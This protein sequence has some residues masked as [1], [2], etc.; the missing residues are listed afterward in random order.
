[1]SKSRYTKLALACCPLFLISWNTA[2]QEEEKLLEEIVVTASSIRSSLQ[3]ALDQK[4]DASSLVEVIKAEDIGKLPDQNLAEV[5][6]NVTGIQIT[7]TAG[8]GTGVQIRGTDANRTEINGVS[9]V[10]SGAGRSGINF[11]DVSA[12]IIAAVEVT[13]SPEAKTIEGSVGGTINL[14]TIRPLDLDEPLV[15]A[16]VQGE[17]SSLSEDGGASPRYSG[18][19]GNSWT[20]EHGDFGVVI[21]AS[22]SEQNANAFRPRADRDNFVAAGGNPSSDDQFLPNQFFVQDYDDFEFETTNF[23]GAFEWQANDNLKLYFDAVLNDQQRNEASSRVQTSGLSSLRSVANI[24]EFENVDFGS[25]QGRN[26]SQDLG[27]IDAAVRGIIPAQLDGDLDPNLRFSGDTNSR[28]TESEILRIGG[29]W[30]EEKWTLR[31][32]ASSSTSDTETPSINTT[33]N[34]INPNTP[35]GTANE[36]G[37]PIE[38]DLTGGALTFGIAESEA[39]A[40]T[41]EQLLNP[42]NYR[43]RDINVSQDIAENTEDAFRVDFTYYT[44]WN[45]ITSIDV[46]YRY[47]ETTSLRDEVGSN[48]SLRQLVDSPSGDSFAD[49][50]AAGPDN[51]NDADGRDL[52]FPDFLTIDPGQVE[53]NPQAVLDGLNEAILAH[54]AITGSDEGGI[55]SPSS[56]NAAFFDISEETQA[57]YAQANFEYGPVR[58]NVG[59]RYIDTDLTSR[60]NTELIEEDGTRTITPSVS[61]SSYDLFL[62]RFNLVADVTENVLVRFGYS[63]D[64]RRPDFDDLS[65]AFTFSTSPNPAVDTG[66]PNLVPEEVES[67]DLSADWYFAPASV[68]SVGLFYK[69][70]NG[71][72]TNQDSAPFEDPVTG[73]RD[74]TDPCEGGGIFNPIADPNVFAPPG[75]P[76]GVCVPVTQTINGAGTT[77][78]EGIEIT[79]QYDLGQF[80]EQL[81]WA[82]GFGFIFNLTEQEFDGSEDFFTAT[83]RAQTIFNALGA[84]EEVTQE[85]QLLNLSETAYNFTVYYER[86]GLSARMRYTWR[87]AHRSEDFGS[88]SSRPFGFPVVQEERGQLNA[89]INYDINENFNIGLEAVNITEEEVEQNC[90]NEGALLCFQGL[91]DRRITLGLSYRM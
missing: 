65:T 32:E 91:T 66:N 23:A 90:V 89:S 64:I 56:S 61:S 44:E 52:F 6:E 39:N 43:L 47:N 42:A 9:T 80:E 84:T 73:F 71:V 86:Y 20:T 46:G 18:T 10:G 27:N 30:A 16:R 21:S 81:G 19:F 58:G 4:R 57:F 63:E 60:G 49:L 85:A 28:D 7:R 12:S 26:G 35:V 68:L 54:Q 82:S 25:L 33:L 51:F 2:A 77:T 55:D 31:I 38:F 41:T 15:A 17:Q 48:L 88:T 22:Y 59:F 3:S 70:R 13:K 50:L 24:T 40:P 45:G 78:Q 72:F 87:D 67:F 53:S 79:F 83:P 8:V 34:F 5:L 29:E 1:M 69:E 36:N 11:E 74:I 14:K 37:S 62:P 75:T 76:V